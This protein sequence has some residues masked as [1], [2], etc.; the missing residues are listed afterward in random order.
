MKTHTVII[1]S[2]KGIYTFDEVCKMLSSAGINYKIVYKN[3]RKAI[4]E[5]EYQIS[6]DMIERRKQ[7]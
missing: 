1:N 5:L 7:K 2:S 3:R 6:Y 4:K